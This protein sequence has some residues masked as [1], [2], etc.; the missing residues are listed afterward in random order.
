LWNT[1][2]QVDHARALF[3]ERGPF[4]AQNLVGRLPK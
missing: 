2:G 4:N 3:A 1:R